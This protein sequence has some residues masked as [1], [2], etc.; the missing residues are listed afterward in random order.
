MLI[1]LEFVFIINASALFLVV[2]GLIVLIRRS[3]KYSRSIGDYD[4]QETLKWRIIRQVMLMFLL[5]LCLT[6]FNFIAGL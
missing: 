5:A 6:I 1:P 4:V 3:L 2:F